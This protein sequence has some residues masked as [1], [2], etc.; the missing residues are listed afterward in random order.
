MDV[1]WLIWEVVLGSLGSQ[2][3]AKLE[4]QIDAERGSGVEQM[5]KKESPRLSEFP[6]LVARRWVRG[7]VD[8]SPG[9]KRF[10]KKGEKKNGKKEEEWSG[11]KGG[12]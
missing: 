4:S 2:F 9:G 8:L 1:N 7:E 5:L 3:V 12:R 6:G 11:S 10:G